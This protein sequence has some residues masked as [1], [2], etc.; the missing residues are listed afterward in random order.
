MKWLIY[1]IIVAVFLFGTAVFAQT[2]SSKSKI[3]KKAEPVADKEDFDEADFSEL[4]KGLF[5]KEDF[6]SSDEQKSYSEDSIGKYDYFQDKNGDGVD[7][8][9]NTGASEKK[10]EASSS[11]T[12]IKTENNTSNNSHSVKQRSGTTGS[13]KKPSSTKRRK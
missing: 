9:L 5:D 13:S 6:D 2:A 12:M 3:A 11:K 4:L 8:R 7:D 10:S 1:I